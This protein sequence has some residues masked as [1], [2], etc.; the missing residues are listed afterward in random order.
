[1]HDCVHGSLKRDVLMNDYGPNK[2]K[3]REKVDSE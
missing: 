2:L 3:A 1:M